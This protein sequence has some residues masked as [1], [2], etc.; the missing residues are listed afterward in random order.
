MQ[1]FSFIEI[2]TKEEL[3]KLI[4]ELP[5]PLEGLIRVWW[6]ITRRLWTG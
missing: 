3:V 1:D 5:P 6:R 4:N 2:S